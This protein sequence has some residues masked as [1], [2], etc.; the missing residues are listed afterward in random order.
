MTHYHL[1]LLGPGIHDGRMA[2]SV[3]AEVLRLLVDGT[4]RVVR[5]RVEGR[6]TAHGPAPAWL[7]QAADFE[8]VALTPGSAVLALDAQEIT[9]PG[10]LDQIAMFDPLEETETGISLLKAS[11]DGA[12]AGAA[13]TVAV[14]DGLL[15][16]IEGWQR[17]VS[18]GVEAELS[19]D[20]GSMTRITA[21]GIARVAQLRKQTPAPQRVRVAGWL[22][23]IRHSDRMF[24]LKLEDGT[25]LRG[26]A[27][28][29]GT[30]RLAGLFGRKALVSGVAVFRPSG[31]VLRIDA[32]RIEPA[33]EDFT[34]WSFEPR[35]ALG[36]GAVEALRRLQ[37]ARSGLA[38]IIGKW[39]GDESDE[40]VR[41]SL[42]ALS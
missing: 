22:D 21:D 1:R 27:E 17:V 33:G 32:D 41:R 25:T 37:G 2:G 18:Q 13:D 35:P 39:P 40:E 19:D 30:D 34:L 28:D 12:M 42:E 3:M 7:A 38:R 9:G 10:L 20:R 31:R 26:I 36:E 29:V 23:L 4:R 11:V 24:T 5:L 8:V 14:D 6:S 16:A 15:E